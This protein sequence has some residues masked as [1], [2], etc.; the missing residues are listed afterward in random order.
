MDMMAVVLSFAI[1]WIILAQISGMKKVFFSITILLCCCLVISGCIKHPKGDLTINPTMTAN[2]D[3]EPTFVAATVV[4]TLVT[5][6]VNDTTNTLIIT[7]NTN[8]LQATPGG[9]QIILTITN[10]KNTTGTFSLI[11]GETTETYI[12]NGVIGIGTE[13]IVSVT[14]ITSNSING[15]FS[16]STS[17]GF[18]IENGSFSVGIP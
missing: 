4:P 1:F 8:L 11:Q 9:D 7:G 14:S 12:H 15:Y 17:N 10:Y 3:T 5:S 6:Q 18:G 13:G 16:F 2:I